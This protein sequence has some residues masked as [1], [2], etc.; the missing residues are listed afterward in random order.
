MYALRTLA[1]AEL[2]L[3]AFRALVELQDSRAYFAD[4]DTPVDNKVVNP[5][6]LL[7]GSIGLHFEDAGE[8]G[9][10]LDIQLGRMT[11]NV[12]SRR[13]LSRNGYR[14]TINAHNGLHLRWQNEEGYDVRVFAVLPVERLPDEPDARGNPIVFDRERFE[15]V[16]WGGFV[17]VP[18]RWGI[19]LD[20]YLYGLHDRVDPRQLYTTGFRA[21][22]APARGEVDF[23]FETAGQAGRSQL[24]HVT[25]DNGEPRDLS[26]LAGFVHAS[27]G[28]TF[29][30][31]WKPRIRAQY[32]Y[33]TGDYDPADDTSHRFDTLFGSRGFEYGATGIYGPF[34]RTNIGSPGLRF[35]AEP[36]P[37]L[38]LFVAYRLYWLASGSDAWSQADLIDPSGQ[39]GSFIGHQ[40]EGRVRWRPLSNIR[41]DLGFAHIFGGDYRGR[42]PDSPG[43]DPS[44]LYAELTLSI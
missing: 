33:A 43:G 5:L 28:Y 15:T 18:R 27:V 32:D 6:E 10:T 4:P 40:L 13:L 2:R 25:A 19:V 37:C 35:L 20:A 30:V 31:A 23:D 44:L 17:A 14:N 34:A 26:H 38:D 1:R 39:S 29:D 7:Q 11:L 41:L 21:H 36:L 24:D 42:A 8:P 3:D 12:S 9:A 16:L 22:R